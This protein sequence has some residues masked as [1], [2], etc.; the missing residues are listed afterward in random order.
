MVI[1]ELIAKLQEILAE[2]GDLEVTYIDN[3]PFAE[4]VPEIEPQVYYGR[5][6]L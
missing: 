1:T 6:V 4:D 5:V 2:E 3:G